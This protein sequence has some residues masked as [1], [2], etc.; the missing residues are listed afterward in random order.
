MMDKRDII[1]SYV[2]QLNIL[3]HCVCDSSNSLRAVHLGLNW[4]RT[5]QTITRGQMTNRLWG[6]RSMST[7]VTSGAIYRIGF[8]ILLL[9]TVS[10]VLLKV[11]WVELLLPWTEMG[12]FFAVTRFYKGLTSVREKKKCYFSFYIENFS[13]QRRNKN[14]WIY[15]TTYLFNL[16]SLSSVYNMGVIKN[17]T[18]QI[19]YIFKFQCQIFFFSIYTSI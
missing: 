18:I 14:S 16:D 9:K 7:A 3:E 8:L 12:I 11:V 4:S 17:D 19:Q 10:F 5:S 15:M 13:L 1:L 2:K 6:N